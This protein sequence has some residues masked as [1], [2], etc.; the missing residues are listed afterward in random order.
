MRRAQ[1]SPTRRISWLSMMGM[2]TPPT[3][4]PDTEMP[5]AAARRRRSHVMTH[6]MTIVATQAWP[7]PETMPCAR[8]NW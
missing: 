7:K 4:D 1:G 6:A 5:S 2:M 3:A 8:M